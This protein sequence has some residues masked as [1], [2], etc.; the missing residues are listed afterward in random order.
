MPEARFSLIIATLDR[1]H[2]LAGT[3]AGIEK[4][5]RRPAEVI[6][7]DAARDEKT[8]AVCGEWT[9]RLPVR[10]VH[11]EA[12]S[13]ARQ[14]N[15][16]ASI[17]SPESAVLG[18]M[19][20]DITL[21][22][23]ACAKVL[24]AFDRDPDRTIGG[25]AVRI[26]EIERT[27]PSALTRFYYRLQ[28]GFADGT[29][30][31][32]LFGPAINC[33]P[34]YSEPA[35]ADGTLIPADWLN[36]GCVFYRREPFLCERF[37]DF[38]GYSF[39]EDVHCSARIGK[40]HRLYFHT[41]ARCSHREGTGSSKNDLTALARQRIHNQRIVARDV[42]GLRGP[43]FMWRFFLHRLFV[44]FNILRQRRPGWTQDLRGT[45]T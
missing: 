4:Q 22:P 2:E 44:T 6:V 21:E 18:F 34:C 43:G 40:T 15:E 36:S 39:M 38:D 41:S 9:G 5:G 42:L 33:L 45:W 17:A 37:P 13:S 10:W 11:S 20:D 19:D 16:G 24:A 7:V 1:A 31:G 14:R 23:D 32:R 28:S 35:E 30:G 26:N 8:K 12:R 27:P 29:Y 25:I 3:F